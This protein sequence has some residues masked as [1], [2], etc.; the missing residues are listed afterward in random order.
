MRKGEKRKEERKKKKEKEKNTFL[1][2]LQKGLLNLLKV[3]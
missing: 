2:S 3:K 1:E